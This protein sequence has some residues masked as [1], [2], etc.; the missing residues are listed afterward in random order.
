MELKNDSKF[1]IHSYHELGTGFSIQKIFIHNYLE[2]NSDIEIFIEADDILG[3][4]KIDSTHQ[5]TYNETLDVT[6]FKTAIY[7]QDNWQI[8]D[9]LFTNLGIRLNYFEFNKDFNI[10]PRISAFYNLLENS[11]FNIAWGHYYQ[12]PDYY[13]FK[14]NYATSQNP[15]NQ[16]AEHYICGIRQKLLNLFELKI[17]FY[18]KK[19]KNLISY[20]DYLWRK[21]SAQKNDAIGFA[22]G[23]DIQLKYNINNF[24][25]WFSYSYLIAKEDIADDNLGYY[26]RPSDQRHTLSIVGNW[27]ITSNWQINGKMLY[28]S[29]FPYTPKIFDN[30]KLDF[31]DGTKNSFY[32]PAYKRIDL[33]IS[34]DF[35][36][37]WGQINAY[38]E[39]INLLNSKNVYMYE[40]YYLNEY[41]NA[42]KKPKMLL[43]RLP[44]FGFKVF[45]SKNN[46]QN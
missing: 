4:S 26:P 28:G 13:D 34:R 3:N 38:F 35:N 37:G 6:T 30:D 8:T 17:D 33:R 40:Q 21:L 41:G 20:N 46:I 27:N 36:F 31:V 7:L 24:Y 22:K 1:K 11:S 5:E 39:I 19:Y 9:K 25:G 44:N 45:F 29:G 14:Y 16:Y 32:L 15:K 42:E 23:T 12:S 2:D 43:P 18:Y 10:S